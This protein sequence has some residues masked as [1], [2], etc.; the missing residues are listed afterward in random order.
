MIIW[1]T[2]Q[3]GAGKTTLADKLKEQYYPDAFRIDGDDLRDLFTNK[4]YSMKGRVANV[5]AA[6]KIARYLHNQGQ[7]VIVSLVSPYID[8][9]EEFKKEGHV[10]EVYVHTEE[11]RG[12]E[13]FHVEGYQMP[14]SDCFYIDTS[15]RDVNESLKELVDEI[16]TVYREMAT[17]A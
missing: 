6:Q 12:R 9:R 5:D 10:I 8:Q 15:Y 14:Q 16:F 3:P 13:K 1:F 2:G 17:L 11:R 7:H 4:D